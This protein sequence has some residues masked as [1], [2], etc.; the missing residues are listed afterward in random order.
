LSCSALADS[1]G[2][3]DPIVETLP[4]RALNFEGF[5]FTPASKQQ[6]MEGLALAIQRRAVG[7]LEGP[8]RA[9]LE[10]FE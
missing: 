6:L 8:M 9:E 10:A 7:V 2:V 5:K 4:R 1:T 3:G